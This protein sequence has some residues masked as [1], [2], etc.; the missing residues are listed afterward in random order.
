MAKVQIKPF[1]KIAAGKININD[2][3]SNAGLD[4][5]RVLEAHPDVKKVKNMRKNNISH[6]VTGL[7]G[8]TNSAIKEVK[9]RAKE[10]GIKLPKEMENVKSAADLGKGKDN[11]ARMYAGYIAWVNDTKMNQITDNAFSSYTPHQ[12]DV[13]LSYLHNVDIS[14]MTTGTAGSLIDAIKLHNEDEVIR[15]IFMKQDGSLVDYE[16][17]RKENKR[18]IGNRLMATMQWWYNPEADVV[19]SVAE[20]D[21]LYS[22]TYNEAGRMKNMLAANAFLIEDTKRRKNVGMQEDKNPMLEQ[23]QPQAKQPQ[24]PIAAPKQAQE[25]SILEKLGRI[26][27]DSINPLNG[28]SNAVYNQ[29]ANNQENILNNANGEQA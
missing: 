5:L 28:L 10:S 21:K 15:R 13:L 25:P 24:Q 19:N 8:I 11:L 3:I 2:Y 18:G 29:V 17:L 14:Q 27:M 12:R 4:G 22:T 26:A 20:K 1:K 9:L 6:D 23:N 7:Y 16:Q